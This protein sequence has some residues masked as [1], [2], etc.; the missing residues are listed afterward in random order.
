VFKAF[1]KVDCA[2]ALEHHWMTGGGS[3]I[4]ISQKYVNTDGFHHHHP[5]PKVHWVIINLERKE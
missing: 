4:S 1:D 3:S 5:I 2:M